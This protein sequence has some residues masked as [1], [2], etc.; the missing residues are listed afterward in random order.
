MNLLAVTA[1]PKASDLTWTLAKN[2]ITFL[3]LFAV[4]CVAIRGVQIWMRRGQK[5]T[6][7]RDTLREYHELYRRGEI[8]EAEFQQIH[9]QISSQH[10]ELKSAL[11]VDLENINNHAE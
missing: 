8:S 3:V 10:P 1:L 2:G 7:V 4:A 6:D 5:S 11:K 9:R